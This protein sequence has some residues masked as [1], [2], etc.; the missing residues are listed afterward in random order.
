ME[1][2][3]DSSQKPKFSLFRC[4]YC[5]TSCI[6]VETALGPTIFFPSEGKSPSNASPCPAPFSSPS[7]TSLEPASC[8]P[9][10]SA[11]AELPPSRLFVKEDVFSFRPSAGCCLRSASATEL[12]AGVPSGFRSLHLAAAPAY[13]AG[14]TTCPRKSRFDILLDRWPFLRADAPR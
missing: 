3:N 10:A 9:F 2:A 1:A 7:S 8:P 4:C 6:G 14:E 11:T 12:G 13:S 5:S